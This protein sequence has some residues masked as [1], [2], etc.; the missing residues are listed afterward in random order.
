MFYDLGLN[1][2]VCVLRR[3]LPE[4]YVRLNYSGRISN[5]IIDKRICTKDQKTLSLLRDYFTYDRYYIT[6][7][8]NKIF[9][10]HVLT[11]RELGSVLFI[12]DLYVFSQVDEH[13]T[14]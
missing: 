3:I 7:I 4:C 8:N 2:S 5:D 14:S 13:S 12:K 11:V 1:L 10:L 9:T 6:I